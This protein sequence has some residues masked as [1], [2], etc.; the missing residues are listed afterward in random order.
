[1]PSERRCSVSEYSLH[2]PD[3]AAEIW[4]YLGEESKA[5]EDFYV[6]LPDRRPR[7]INR[8]VAYGCELGKL[9]VGLDLVV[10]RA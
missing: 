7:D 4:S 8:A 6:L 2:L 1:M 5:L 9:H 10:R 3:I